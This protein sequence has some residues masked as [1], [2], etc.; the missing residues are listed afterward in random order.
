MI[1]QETWMAMCA[2]S[3]RLRSDASAEPGSL[4]L[5]FDPYQAILIV[6]PAH[7]PFA[8]LDS[9]VDDPY[10]DF[11][12]GV[13]DCLV[14]SSVAQVLCTLHY[15]AHRGPPRPLVHFDGGVM[16]Y[17]FGHLDRRSS[18]EGYCCVIVQR[19]HSNLADS[20]SPRNSAHRSQTE[21]RDTATRFT[22][23]DI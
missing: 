20:I 13:G 17:G 3:S 23:R 19:Y 10:V 11:C 2:S 21:L 16:R 12:D 22:D 8:M 6:I 4:S 15:T 1:G 14:S 7:I 9:R 18:V 5:G